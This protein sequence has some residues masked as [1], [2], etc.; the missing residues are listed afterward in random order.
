MYTYAK[1]KVNKFVKVARVLVGRAHSKD[2]VG[3]EVAYR[4]SQSFFLKIIFL[5]LFLFLGLIL[6]VCFGVLGFFI[7]INGIF[8]A[9]QWS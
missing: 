8:C 6:F 4:E 2:F 7:V 3:T 5:R 9:L 1:Y